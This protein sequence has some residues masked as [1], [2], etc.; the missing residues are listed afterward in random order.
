MAYAF[1]TSHQGSSSNSSTTQLSFTIAAGRQLICLAADGANS[2]NGLSIADNLGNTYVQRKTINDT[3]NGESYALFDCLAPNTGAATLTLTLS[4]GTTPNPGLIVLEYTG[5]A[6][7]DQAT[8]KFAHSGWAT[9]TNGALST[10]ITPG[11]QPCMLLGF[12]SGQGGTTAPD[13]GANSRINN[14]TW[15]QAQNTTIEDYRLTSLSAAQAAFTFSLATASNVIIAATYL[16]PSVATVIAQLPTPGPGISPSARDQF[17]VSVRDTSGRSGSM[18][19]RCY[20]V[21]AEYGSLIAGAALLGQSDSVSAVYGQLIGT[22]AMPA[23]SVSASIS[24]GVLAQSQANVGLIPRGG[25]GISPAS[26]FQFSTMILDETLLFILSNGIITSASAA[27]GRVT[28]LGGM[29]GQS[30]AVSTIYQIAPNGPMQGE[31]TSATT[32]LGRLN[33]VGALTGTCDSVSISYGN[34]QGVTVSQMQGVSASVSTSYGQVSGI[35]LAQMTGISINVSTA[36]GACFPLFTERVMATSVGFYQNLRNIGD[37]FD[38]LV[39]DF[40]DDTTDYIP[41][42]IGSPFF[43]W[44]V[45]VSPTMPLSANAPS[46]LVGPVFNGTVPQSTATTNKPRTVY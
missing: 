31:S 29:S 42:Q 18:S 25:P 33:A 39:N 6:S 21:S 16:E 1:Q 26:M 7:F 46:P 34:L 10:A 36:Y 19:G 45:I 37:V 28:G 9:T 30:Y 38:V 32:V 11:V 24:F 5:L 8:S 4:G 35:T 17:H 20:S 14:T 3:F 2:A 12:A 43:G 27:F 41:G 22:G 15:V 40:S 13:A 23:V 44:M